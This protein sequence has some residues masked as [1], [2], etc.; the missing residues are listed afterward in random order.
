MYEP[1][2]LNSSNFSDVK[3]PVGIDMTRG[4]MEVITTLS[5]SVPPAPW[6]ASP[7]SIRVHAR[8]PYQ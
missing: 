3:A 2:T 5:N 8:H 1:N 6:D 4:S 7:T